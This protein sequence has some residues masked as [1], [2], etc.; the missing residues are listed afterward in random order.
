V[1][2]WIESQGGLAGMAQHN[3]RKAAIVYA[4]IDGSDGFYR[5]HA[6]QGSRSQMNITFR[7]P[8]EELEKQFVAAAQKQGMRSWRNSSWPPRRSRA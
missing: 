1:L 2:G 4:A 3:E 5:G 7:L 8:S 6:E